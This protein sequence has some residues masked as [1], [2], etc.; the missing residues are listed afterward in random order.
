MHLCCNFGCSTP[1]VGAVCAQKQTNKQTD[2]NDTK[3]KVLA[4]WTQ[5][6]LASCMNLLIASD[7]ET[8]TH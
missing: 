8:Q 6:Y 5:K 7:E 3:T 2:M 1:R 4:R